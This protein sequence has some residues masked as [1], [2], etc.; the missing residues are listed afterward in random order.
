MR[1]INAEENGI[2]VKTGEKSL[3]NRVYQI[4]VLK[5]D[6]IGPAVVDE[7]IRIVETLEKQIAAIMEGKKMSMDVTM[8]N[9]HG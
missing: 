8:Q 5:G 2:S 6:G 9:N 1:V 3:E 7:S 4:A